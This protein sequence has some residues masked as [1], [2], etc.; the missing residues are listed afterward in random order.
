[1]DSIYAIAYE[2]GSNRTVLLTALKPKVARGCIEITLKATI[3][4][5]FHMSRVDYY[6]GE[7]GNGE[8][9]ASQNFSCAVF[10]PDDEIIGFLRLT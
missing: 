6:Y 1:M 4:K 10:N 7:V 2:H 5:S 3:D 8:L 9:I